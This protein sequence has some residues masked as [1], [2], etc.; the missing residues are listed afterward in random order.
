MK[1]LAGYWKNK[2]YSRIYETL[3]QVEYGYTIDEFQRD[4]QKIESSNKF[5]Y[6]VYLNSVE[7]SVKNVLLL[8]EFLIYTDTFFHDI[9]P[10]VGYYLRHTVEKFP[11]NPQLLEWICLTFEGNP[12]SPFTLEEIEVFRKH[13]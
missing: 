13:L 7:C 10:V 9:Y 4:F 2:E 11:D 3:K 5:C 8:C 12:D 6:L 1:R